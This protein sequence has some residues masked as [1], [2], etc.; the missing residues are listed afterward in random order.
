M[1]TKSHILLTD[2]GLAQAI[3]TTRERAESF[4]ERY[5]HWHKVDRKAA[6]GKLKELGIRLSM[7]PAESQPG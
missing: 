3:I 6:E 1:E 5:M 2:K 4:I 7:L